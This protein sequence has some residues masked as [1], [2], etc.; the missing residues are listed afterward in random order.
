MMVYFYAP[1]STIQIKS[2]PMPPNPFF[3]PVKS[4]FSYFT[5]ANTPL[6]QPVPPKSHLGETKADTPLRSF[7]V[8]R[9]FSTRVQRLRLSIM[10]YKAATIGPERKQPFS[11]ALLRTYYLQFFYL[12]K[13]WS[14]LSLVTMV[15]PTSVYGG[16]WGASTLRQSSNAGTVLW[17][18]Q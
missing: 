3:L 16:I 14:T 15:T 4:F 8:K 10:K 5:G 6:F 7:P 17:L 1:P 2:D 11:T 9:I 18:S 12:W 13:Y